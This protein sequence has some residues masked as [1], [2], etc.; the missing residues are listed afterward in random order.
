MSNLLTE[1]VKHVSFRT[2]LLLCLLFID[3]SQ[4]SQK[5]TRNTVK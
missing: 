2:E 4:F 1:N 3:Y 5:H